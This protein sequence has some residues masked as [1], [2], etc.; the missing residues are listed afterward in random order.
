MDLQ[1]KGTED[2]YDDFVLAGAGMFDEVYGGRN[3]KDSVQIVKMCC[4]F[5]S[6]ASDVFN[7]QVSSWRACSFQTDDERLVER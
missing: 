5:D 7:R 4:L 3:F 6:D 1:K 2:D